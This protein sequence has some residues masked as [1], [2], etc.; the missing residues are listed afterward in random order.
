MVFRL[1][2]L[3]FD[4]PGIKPDTSA[5]LRLEKVWNKKKVHARNKLGLS[6]I[7]MKD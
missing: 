1:V 7:T 6:F 5:H 3:N 4:R 2:T